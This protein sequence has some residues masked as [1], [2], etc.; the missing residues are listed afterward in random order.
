MVWRYEKGRIA[1]R[2]T[3]ANMTGIE[4]LRAAAPA[5][6][7]TSSD[8]C[9]PYATEERASEENTARPISLPIVWLGASAVASGRPINQWRQVLRGS[10]RG[11]CSIIVEFL[12]SSRIIS[13]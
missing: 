10:D 7:S 9:G 11:N 12:L 6:D 8:S 4:V 13:S 2:A 1:S 5:V 3:M